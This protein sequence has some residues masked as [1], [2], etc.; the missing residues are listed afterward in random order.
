MQRVQPPE[1]ARSGGGGGV[2][3][4]CQLH[5]IMI[6][7]T[8]RGYVGAAADHISIPNRAVY[9]IDAGVGTTLGCTSMWRSKVRV[10]LLLVVV[11]P[12]NIHQE[13]SISVRAK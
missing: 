11:M 4:N 2:K 3:I 6:S 13:R 7:E 12:P 5:T 10:F 1:G 8:A 9:P